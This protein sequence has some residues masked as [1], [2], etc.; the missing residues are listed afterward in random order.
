[1]LLR[2]NTNIQFNFLHGVCANDNALIVF[3]EF[4]YI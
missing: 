1:M 2:R 3:V 4:N